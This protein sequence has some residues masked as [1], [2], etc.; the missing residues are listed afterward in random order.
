MTKEEIKEQV[1]MRDV[2]IRYGL[3]TNRAGFIR[4]P[5]HLGDREAS[6]KI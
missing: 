6:M 1:S 2:L 5:F 4:C 3:Q